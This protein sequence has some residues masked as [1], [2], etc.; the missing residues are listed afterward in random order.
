MKAVSDLFNSCKNLIN[1]KFSQ[2]YNNLYNISNMFRD[3]SS[4]ENIDINPFNNGKL[5]DIFGLFY[6]CLSLS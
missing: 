4:L 6:G 1:V 2:N 3:C 5:I